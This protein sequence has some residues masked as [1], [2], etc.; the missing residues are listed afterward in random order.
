MQYSDPSNA[1][2]PA[3]GAPVILYFIVHNIELVYY[4]QRSHL[5]TNAE[6]PNRTNIQVN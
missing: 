3:N 2:K 5:G 1:R 6:D 4:T